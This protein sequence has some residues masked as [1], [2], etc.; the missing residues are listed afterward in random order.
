VNFRYFR[1]SLNP[2][3]S[4]VER[5]TLS[6]P[7]DGH[8][9]RQLHPLPVNARE[10]SGAA[11]GREPTLEERVEH[12]ERRITEAEEKLERRVDD[13]SARIAQLARDAADIEFDSHRR[14]EATRAFLR[15]ALTADLGRRRLGVVLLMI[16]IV[17]ATAG[18]L[19]GVSVR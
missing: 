11:E 9:A 12:A 15:E 10:G 13:L 14:E 3:S 4:L 8:A 16:G 7:P 1:C 2:V 18:N 5:P 6:R 17:A 19:L